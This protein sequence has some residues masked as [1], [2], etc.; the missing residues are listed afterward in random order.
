MMPGN[1]E[2]PDDFT[3]GPGCGGDYQDDHYDHDGMVDGD[4]PE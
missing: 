3:G 1:L 4:D 2:G